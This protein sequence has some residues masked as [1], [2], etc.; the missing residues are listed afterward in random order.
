MQLTLLEVPAHEPSKSNKVTQKEVLAVKL[1]P[2]I[3]NS[4]TND[5][6]RRRELD[7]LKKLRNQYLG[8]AKSSK[9]P[10]EIIFAVM[11]ANSLIPQIDRLEGGDGR[12]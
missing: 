8:V 2:G 12:K 4:V 6:L 10:K 11:F 1:S 5:D 9:N 3:E 7:K